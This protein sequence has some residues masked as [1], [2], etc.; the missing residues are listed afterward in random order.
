MKYTTGLT[1]FAGCGVWAL[2]E[3]PRGDGETINEIIAKINN[4]P[5]VSW[6]AGINN[7]FDSF[8]KPEEYSNLMGTLMDEE[9]LPEKKINVN[10]D[11]IPTSFDPRDQWPQCSTLTQIRDQGTCG[12]CWAFGAA[13]AFSDRACIQSNGNINVAYSTQDILSCCRTCGMGCN[14]GY[15]GASWKYFV[16][17]GICTGGLYEGTGCKPYSIA[18]CEHHTTGDRP[19]C[20]DLPNSK[21]PACTSTC[22]AGY[23]ADTYSNDKLYCS[24]SYS[25]GSRRDLEAIQTELMTNGPIEVAFTVYEDFM[26]YTSGV[27]YHVSGKSLGG[28]AVKLLGWGVDADTQM[29]YW[30]L[31]NSWNDDWGENGF[32]RM[33]R[34][35]NECG[36]ENSG[37]AG[38]IAF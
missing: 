20:S 12:S 4:D 33:R 16:N 28:H 18:P 10:A 36:L 24:D 17:N 2:P 30:L 5:S 19:D 11:A 13:E 26:S 29:D 37:V 38:M 25:V 9:R 31:A 27:Y 7:K 6:K 23:T 21:T 35:T 15:L 3:N 8:K 1:I 34:G 22:V 32:F 14:G